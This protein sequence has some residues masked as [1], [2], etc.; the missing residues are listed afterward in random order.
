MKSWLPWSA[1]EQIPQGM[2]LEITPWLNGR[3]PIQ[4]SIVIHNPDSKL[5]TK[6]PHLHVIVRGPA[7]LIW[8]PSNQAA[9]LLSKAALTDGRKNRNK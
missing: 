3:N 6:F 9:E 2:A 8:Y 7:I 5:S 4:A 1:I